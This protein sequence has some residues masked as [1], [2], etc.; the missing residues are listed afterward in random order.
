MGI[1]AN[2]NRMDL[3]TYPNVDNTKSTCKTLKSK[4][5]EF[6]GKNHKFQ[7]KH[8]RR[9]TM[10]YVLLIGNNGPYN[11]C[12]RGVKHVKVNETGKRDNHDRQ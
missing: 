3:P 2:E 9:K 12:T 6:R 7:Q 11:V 8:K 5:S 10:N 4:T 1:I